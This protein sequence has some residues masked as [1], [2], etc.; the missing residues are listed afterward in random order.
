MFLICDLQSSVHA[1]SSFT[2]T[3]SGPAFGSHLSPSAVDGYE[4]ID[5]R[6]TENSDHIAEE[7]ITNMLH[8]LRIYFFEFYKWCIFQQVPTAARRPFIVSIAA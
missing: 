4:V 3:V 2:A 7:L 5:E 6:E 1:A 8:R